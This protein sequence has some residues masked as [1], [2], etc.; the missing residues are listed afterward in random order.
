MMRAIIYHATARLIQMDGAL[1]LKELLEAGKVV[2][3]IDRT[4]PLSA[5]PEA[6]RYL[7]A[8]HARGKIVVTLE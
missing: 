8:K 1:A 5:V 3:V 4:H 2:P 6:Y 7:E